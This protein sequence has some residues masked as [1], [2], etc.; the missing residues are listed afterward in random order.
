[1]KLEGSSSTLSVKNDGRDLPSTYVSGLLPLKTLL[2]F[3][4]S[5]AGLFLLA[6]LLL[7]IAAL[8]KF[9]SPGPVM[10]KQI[11]TGQNGHR[12]RIYKF[13]TMTV[14]ED[15]ALIR[16]A[17]QGDKRITR[18]GYWLRKTSLDELPQLVNVVRGEMSLVGPRPHALAH[19]EY[20]DR[21]IETYRH[22]F[23]VKPGLTGWA[24]VNGSRG[25]TP[26]ISDM[27][28]RVN[29]DVWYIENRSLTLDIAIIAR[30]IVSE[31][32][33]KTNAY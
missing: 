11:R 32:T 23:C 24:Q 19:D 21:E 22:R 18:V 17:T 12:F 14:M 25:E 28:R 10:F 31:I 4:L 29:F 33:R 26:T 3:A 27:Q 7:I 13:R 9:D 15:G 5:A 8:I 16:Q 2:D 30:T 20:Y 1:M 6:P